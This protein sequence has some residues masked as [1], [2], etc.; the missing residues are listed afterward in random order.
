[1]IRSIPLRARGPSCAF[2]LL[3]ALSAGAGDAGQAAGGADCAPTPIEVLSLHGTGVR[4]PQV[5]LV[6]GRVGREGAAWNSPVAVELDRDQ[7]WVVFDFDRPRSLRA[8]LLQAD[9]DE[10]FQLEGSLDGSTWR[11]LGEAPPLPGMP[12]LRSRAVTFDATE[13]RFVRLTPG[14]GD[15][16][17]SVAELQL[18]CVSPAAWEPRLESDEVTST[19]NSGPVR[20]RW[21]DVTSRWWQLALA[22]FALAALAFERRFER[23]EGTPVAVDGKFARRRRAIERLFLLVAVATWFNFGAFHFGNF[24]H[25][26]DTFHYYIGAKYFAEL[27]YDG[28]YDCVAVADADAR[29]EAAAQMANRKVR[30]LRRNVL[31]PATEILARSASCR[32]RFTAERWRA[33]E[34][35]VAWFRERETPAR[36]EEVTA[37]HGFNATPVWRIAGTALAN[38]APA[39]HESITALALL[40]PL[41]FLGGVALLVWAFGVRVTA[42]AVLALATAFPARFFWTGGAFL[43]WDWLFLL[44][45]ALALARRGRPLAAGAALGGSALLRLF[46]AILAAGPAVQ[47]GLAVVAAGATGFTLRA[48]GRSSPPLR[49]LRN[50]L[51]TPAT[52]DALRFLAGFALAV[53]LL[54]PASLALDGGPAA[55]REFARN[56]AKHS[57]TPLTNNMGIATVLTWRP[58]EIGRKLNVDGAPEPWAKWKTAR[59]AA[60][61]ETRPAQLALAAG[62]LLL[63][64]LALRRERE[65]WIALALAAC[66][67]PFLV[68]MT[69]YY[70]AFLVVPALLV[71]RR[72]AVGAIL[73]VLSAL[74]QFLSLAPFPGM[75]T[76]RDELYTAL[77]LLTVIALAAVLALF[78]GRRAAVPSA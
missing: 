26:W 52:R 43:R 31:V 2:V 25:N 38:L 6:D 9:S 74:G 11:P 32:D 5:A 4:G 42:I 62:A 21:N 41:L 23:R 58:D 59:L 65:G 20:R 49:T 15:G 61:A 54:V 12:G 34:R 22:L 7:S 50:R 69:C 35:D 19:A 16:R 67:V 39:S 46:P 56:T 53:A 27:R 77:S 24:I 70:Y 44:V 37:D 1:M 73:L 13:A 76:W 3:A 18:F 57:T 51:A 60:R 66:L 63:L 45:A 75:P 55:W 68:E 30:D 64:G 36:W 33:F 40:D 72:R 47:V 10:S 78:V 17:T 48:D 28:L 71:E 29:P 8:A 14:P